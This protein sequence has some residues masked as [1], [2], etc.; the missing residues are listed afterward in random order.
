MPTFMAQASFTSDAWANLCKHPE[1]RSAATAKQLE[2]F[3]CKLLS[4]HFSFGDHDV[5]T[6][7]E[8]PDDTAM[9]AAIASAV[10]AGH[11]TSTKTTKLF[12]SDEA[13][14]AMAQAGKT[15]FVPPSG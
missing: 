12:T 4:F 15:K 5:V 6:I 14:T 3:G 11:L 10:S 9:M 13:M 1:D 7:C 8:A 2:A